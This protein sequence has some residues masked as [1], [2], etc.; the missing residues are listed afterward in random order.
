MLS[1]CKMAVIVC[2]PQWVNVQECKDAQICV[3]IYSIQ[4]DNP[5][6]LRSGNHKVSTMELVINSL[7]PSDVIWQHIFWSTLTQ[8]M[9]WCPTAPSH[10]LIQCWLPISEVLWHSSDSSLSVNAQVTILYNEFE[11]YTFI[12]TATSP[13][14]K[15]VDSSNLSPVYMLWGVDATQKNFVTTM[16]SS[17]T[18]NHT[19]CACRWPS[20]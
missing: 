17:S 1:I 19:I 3:Y 10:Y 6:D 14:V 11:N 4:T 9:T 5:A 13:R 20:I 8:V 16:C 18:I 15:W 7:W 12:I 2:R